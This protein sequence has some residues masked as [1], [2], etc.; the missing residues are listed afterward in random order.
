[1]RERER[2][3]KKKKEKLMRTHLRVSSHI[4]SAKIVWTCMLHTKEKITFLFPFYAH[5]PERE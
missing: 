1:M 3:S 4:G 2:E 5:T